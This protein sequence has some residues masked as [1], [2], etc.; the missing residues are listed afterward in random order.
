[1]VNSLSHFSPKFYQITKI[2]SRGKILKDELVW[3]T[4][5]SKSNQMFITDGHQTFFIQDNL[6]IW[7]GETKSQWR[8]KRTTHLPVN[9]GQPIHYNKRQ[10][11]YLN[12]LT[13]V[14]IGWWPL[15]S[16]LC[17]RHVVDL[18]F[19]LWA[20]SPPWVRRSSTTARC[21]PAQARDNTVWS[22]VE[23]L[24]FT[25]APLLIRNW[26]VQKCPARAAFIKGVRPPSD[27]CSWR[28]KYK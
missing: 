28:K 17:S 7:R 4:S 21:P 19:S 20:G 16:N 25:S 8:L 1:M 14:C 22:L 12:R 15:P 6:N 26:T 2:P 13:M 3:C 5:T 23:V 10:I 27:S 24:R 11:C 18:T 9:D